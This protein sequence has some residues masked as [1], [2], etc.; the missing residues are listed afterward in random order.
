MTSKHSRIRGTYA[1]SMIVSLEHKGNI[2]L[3]GSSSS[4]GYPV[5]SSFYSEKEFTNFQKELAQYLPPGDNEFLDLIYKGNPKFHP[6]ESI[7]EDLISGDQDNVD[8]VTITTPGPT[9]AF[10]KC[11]GEY[12]GVWRQGGTPLKVKDRVKSNLPKEFKSKKLGESL[13]S[14]VPLLSGISTKIH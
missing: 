1:E 12:A 4:E 3:L 8:V 6:A 11:K 9:I 7:D 5:F 14:S 10:I 13:S 2:Y